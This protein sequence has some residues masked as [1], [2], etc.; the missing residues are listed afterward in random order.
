METAPFVASDSRDWKRILERILDGRDE[1]FVRVRGGNRLLR[2]FQWRRLVVF[3]M[4]MANL[5]RRIGARRRALSATGKTDFTVILRFDLLARWYLLRLALS[6]A[7]ILVGGVEFGSSH[8]AKSSA[9]LLN[10][11]IPGEAGADCGG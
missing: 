3:V 10:N 1:E 11:L 4:L 8:W 9:R 6:G 7:W 5:W 2:R